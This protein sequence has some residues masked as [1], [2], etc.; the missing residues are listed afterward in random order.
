MSNQ[1]YPH[2]I[3][4]LSSSHGEGF[5][6]VLAEAMLCGVPC[7]ATNVGDSSKII[8]DL[9]IV[10]SPKD[11]NS[12]ADAIERMAA[13]RN[14]PAWSKK[15]RLGRACIINEFGLIKMKEQYSLFGKTVWIERFEKRVVNIMSGSIDPKMTFRTM[16]AVG[17][18]CISNQTDFDA[19][20]F[21]HSRNIPLKSNEIGLQYEMRQFLN[22]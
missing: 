18:L 21:I 3:C 16:C 11:A 20:D 12:L 13:M 10:V 2:W 17:K 22:L 4:I 15:Q 9:G 1:Y 7:I 8:G 19:S 5:P 14:T 6:N